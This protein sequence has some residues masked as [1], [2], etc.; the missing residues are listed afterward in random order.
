MEAEDDLNVLAALL[1]DDDDNDDGD[2]D[3]AFLNEAAELCPETKTPTSPTTQTSTKETSS[4]SCIET[5]KLLEPPKKQSVKRKREETSAK[6]EASKK[7]PGNKEKDVQ[8]DAFSGLYIINPLISSTSMSNRME[9][10]KMILISNISRLL[11]GKDADYD[12]VTIGVLA[13]KLPAKTSSNGKTYGIWKLSDLGAT[14]ANDTVALFLFGEVY[15]KHW[16]TTEGSVIAL[17]NPSILPAK[18]KQS[19]ELALT[20]DNPKKLMMMGISR[21]FGHCLALTKKDGKSCTNIVNKQYGEFCE[22]HITSA[23]KKVQS[24]RIELQSEYKTPNKSP[25][26]KKLCKDMSSSTFM[27]QGKTLT[28]NSAA[29]Q[30][31]KNVSLAALDNAQNVKTSQVTAIKEKPSKTTT[32]NTD[33]PSTHFLDLL[34]QPSVGT[35][36]LVKYLH[37]DKEKQENKKETVKEMSASQ[38]LKNH[39]RDVQKS[40]E[41]ART[42]SLVP[43]LGKG[44]QPGGDIVFDGF[45]QKTSK[46]SALAKHRALS[47]IRSK[48]PLEKS[49]P[50]AVKKKISPLANK[51]VEQRVESNI[52]SSTIQSNE[53]S[54]PEN[55][56]KK[57]RL[58]GP[59]F[60][61]INLNSNEGKRLLR[62]KSLHNDQV[63]SVQAERQEKYFNE[64]EKKERLEDKMK[65]I[66]ELTVTV[67][68]CKKCKYIDESAADICFKENHPLKKTKASK[69]FFACKH[70]GTRAISYS[71]KLPK[72]TCSNCGEMN[73]E[74]ASMYMERKG[75]KIGGETLLVRG[76]EQPKYFNSIQS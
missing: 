41:V 63:E 75:P 68:C 72:V 57:R 35:R 61:V 48:G 21:D 42:K 26:I 30:K 73:F 4:I 66:K 47:M 16:K 52:N 44:I 53:N 27:Y 34:A 69:R 71:S 9:G 64:L 5:P 40:R 13:K 54:S 24:R 36:N 18:E 74:R 50:N 38:L 28:L 12:W 14:T 43:M 17:L 31:T 59:E 20:L 32:N 76:E 37:L 6:E 56:P 55:Q 29:P 2:N 11:K 49:N 58:L 1:D 70:C 45:P 33:K 23:Y 60:G 19:Q 65:A 62:A 7:V 3:D 15:K 22:Y 67:Y 8:M 10:R 39:N 51:N 25:L 46:S